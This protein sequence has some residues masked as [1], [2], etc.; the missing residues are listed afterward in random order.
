MVE[1]PDMEQARQWYASADYADAL[2]LSKVAL[3][4]RLILVE[5]V[6]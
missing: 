2:N 1:F 6:A 5:G 4:R 3:T